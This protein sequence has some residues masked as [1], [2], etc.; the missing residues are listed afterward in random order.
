M[1]HKT[2]GWLIVIAIVLVTILTG[3]GCLS[4]AEAKRPYSLSMAN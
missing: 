1:T 2:K 4:H 3:W